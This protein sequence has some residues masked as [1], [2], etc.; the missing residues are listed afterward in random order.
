VSGAHGR[1]VLLAAALAAAAGALVAGTV[2]EARAARGGGGG[3]GPRGRPA[4]PFGGMMP[5]AGGDDA[6]GITLSADKDD[7]R[8]GESVLVTVEA[9][10]N[11]D[12]GRIDDLK[13]D[14][15]E[16]VDGSESVPEFRMSMGFG[17]RGTSV[18]KRVV[19]QYLLRA[20]KPGRFVLGPVGMDVAGKRYTSATLTLIVRDAH[21]KVPPGAP[22]APSTATDG[23]T[24]ASGAAGPGAG[25]VAAPATAVGAPAP[26]T[27]DALGPIPPERRGLEEDNDALKGLTADEAVG[28]AFTHA[29]V[30]KERVYVGEQITL[31]YYLFIPDDYGLAGFEVTAEPKFDGTWAEELL[32]P[33]KKEPFVRRD[34]FGR[35]YGVALVRRKA[36]FPTSPGA[37]DI[38]P[39]GFHVAVAPARFFGMR[40]PREADIT[41]RPIDV[42][43]APLPAA[44]RPPGFDPA[45]VGA[46]ALTASATDGALRV[47]DA[48]TFR[49]ALDGIG[50][51]RVAHVP[52]L[53]KAA[54]DGWDVYDPTSTT[55]DDS[56]DFLVRGKRVIEQLL[57]A[58]RAGTFTLPSLEL[59]YFDP[60]DGG[61]H[62][63]RSVPIAV[64]VAEAD[65]SAAA[66]RATSGVGAKGETAGASAES[67]PAIGEIR[68]VSALARP[69]VPLHAR[70]LFWG[71]LLAVGPGLLAMVWAGQS[72]VA[73]RRRIAPALTVKRA[74]GRALRRL[75]ASKGGNGSA[76]AHL[77]EVHRALLDYVQEKT[78]ERIGGW[79]RD[80]IRARLPA[81][82]FAPAAVEALA[83]LLEEC[84]AA[85][86]A[87]AP[88]PSEQLAGAAARAETIVQHLARGRASIAA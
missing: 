8:I 53:K 84:E 65:G 82:G 80:E 79:T 47:G 66:A 38:P 33:D 7:V 48:L 6:P 45:N 81:L 74:E 39:M 23:T 68:E 51:Y 17:T 13:T 73:W 5:A 25:G 4:G 29:V 19:R 54:L 35:T 28:V 64:T 14:G 2:P 78:G 46:Y 50:N 15:F 9:G 69:G 36:L 43:V 52:T 27:D 63:A 40:A 88:P 76:A 83:A 58:K 26:G 24:G 41:T 30:S 77:A 86:Y 34:V 21:G 85:R 1:R 71:G 11:A 55:E 75:R 87:P 3:F 31:S 12:S 67:A 59:A 44:G 10:M 20:L 37:L 60:A 62:V 18:F 72:L 61:Y 32:P 56:N 42:D 70:P 57:L 22:A 16:L 49:V